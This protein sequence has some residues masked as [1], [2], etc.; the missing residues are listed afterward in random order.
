M[1]LRALAGM[2]W[3]ARRHT[4]YISVPSFVSDY[5]RFWFLHFECAELTRRVQRVRKFVLFFGF[6]FGV[7][8]F[9]DGID[10]TSFEKVC[11]FFFGFY[12]GFFAL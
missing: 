3:C 8:S 10:G 12:H 9:G 4:I 6:G 7:D 1:A 2:Y 5:F 11:D